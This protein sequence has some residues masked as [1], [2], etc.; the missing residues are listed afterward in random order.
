MPILQ[1]NFSLNTSIAEYRALCEAVQSAFVNLPGLQ[2]KIWIL[3]EK[4]NEAGGLYCFESNQAIDDYLSGPIVAQLK[5]YSALANVSM[6]R[7]EVMEELTLATR[8]PVPAT[9][10]ATA[11]S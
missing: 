1:V 2:W 5:S 3:N 7:F 9:I 6:K 11:A 10:A 8:G 4:Q